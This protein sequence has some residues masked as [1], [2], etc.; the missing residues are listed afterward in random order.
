V[1]IFQPVRWDEIVKSRVRAGME[2]NLTAG[3]LEKLLEI[4][5]QESIDHQAQVMRTAP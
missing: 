1:S 5:H 2:K 4:I 3:F